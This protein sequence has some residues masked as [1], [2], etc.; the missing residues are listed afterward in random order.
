MA[1]HQLTADPNTGEM[2]TIYTLHFCTRFGHAGHYTGWTANLAKRLAEHAKGS[3][4]NLCRKAARAGITWVLVA[5]EPGDKNRERQLKN[6]GGA[7]RRCPVCRAHK[8][9]T[10][11]PPLPVTAGADTRAVEFA[12]AA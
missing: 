2:G 12:T 7:A 5:T 11:V 6:Q 3:G 1:W 10:P 9:G 4:S 8:A